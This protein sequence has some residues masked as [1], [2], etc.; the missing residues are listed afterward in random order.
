MLELN[1]KYIGESLKLKDHPLSAASYMSPHSL[2]FLHIPD[3][4]DP[5][6]IFD[7]VNSTPS[8]CVAK[9]TERKSTDRFASTLR[10]S[11]VLTKKPHL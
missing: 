2:T 9:V 4:A 10:T 3:Y 1:Y 5:N 8:L 6:T 11:T 7:N